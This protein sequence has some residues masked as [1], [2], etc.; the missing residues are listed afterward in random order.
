M[1][2]IQDNKNNSFKLKRINGILSI[3]EKYT[4][5]DIEHLKKF[6]FSIYNFK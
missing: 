4:L 5:A 2:C 1:E 3:L 6:K